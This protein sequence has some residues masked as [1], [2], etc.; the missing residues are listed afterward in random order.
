MSGGAPV[1]VGILG[2]GRMGA[3]MLA[4][5]RRAGIAARGLDLRPPATYG[6]LAPAMTDDPAAFAPGLACV[7]TVVRDAAETEAALFGDRGLLAHAGAL[8]VLALSSTLPPPFVAELR[9]RLPARI[10][11]VDAPMSGAEVAAREARLSFMLGGEAAVL[12]RLAPILGAM[13]TRFHRMGPLGAGMTAKVMN[14][15]VA[16]SS[17]AMTRLALDWGAA[18]GLAPAALLALMHDSSGQTWF[19]SHFEAIEFAR[20]GLAPDNT[21]GILVKDV[22]AA[23][24]AAPAGAPADLPRAVQAAL[25]ALRPLE[26]PAGGAVDNGAP[27]SPYPTDRSI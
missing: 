3:G 11:L 15:L 17:V 2:C 14:N 16:A 27:A 24:A 13:G 25:R 10:A 4:A 20:D 9:A 21:I 22:E 1:P 19:G 6:G 8:E 5:L 26:E 18:Q 7:F 23:L 12:D